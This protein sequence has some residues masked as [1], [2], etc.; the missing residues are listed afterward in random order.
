MNDDAY[1]LAPL[2]Y[3]FPQFFIPHAPQEERELERKN[4]VILNLAKVSMIPS[5]FENEKSE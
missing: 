2:L 3:T 5:S 1:P 4:D